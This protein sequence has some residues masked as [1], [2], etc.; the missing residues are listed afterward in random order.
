MPDMDVRQRIAQMLSGK[1]R[2]DGRIE[3]IL[4][5][6]VRIDNKLDGLIEMFSSYV[7]DRSNSNIDILMNRLGSDKYEDKTVRNADKTG[8]EE[9]VFIPSVDI[10]N[11]RTSKSDIKSKTAKIDG[12]AFKKAMMQSEEKETDE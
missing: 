5:E 4:E 9:L 2:D 10:S 3:L 11:T 8:N 6:I 12:S 7:E 1:R